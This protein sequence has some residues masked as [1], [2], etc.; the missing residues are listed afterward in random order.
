MKKVLVLFMF[1]ALIAGAAYAQETTGTARAVV[2]DPDGA[3]LPGVTVAISDPDIGLQRTGISDARGIVGFRALPPGTYQLTATLD[4][5]QTYKSS[6]QVNLGSET[7]FDFQMKLGA[8][9]DVIEVTGEAPLVDV[10]S[11]VAGLTVSTDDLN[12]KMPVQR[13]ASYVALLAPATV[14]G[15]TAFNGYTPGQNNISMSGA[16]V[17]ENSYQVNGLNITNFRNGIGSTMVPM[18]FVEEM[19]VKTGGYEAEFGRSTGGVINMVTKSGSNSLHGNFSLYYEPEDLQEQE[20][21][22]YLAPNSDETRET[23]EANASLGGAILKDKLFYFGFVR[24]TDNDFL[25]LSYGQ[26]TRRETSDPYWGG[27][28]DWNITPSHRL[29][30]TYIS[31]DVAVDVTTYD[32]YIP[33]VTGEMCADPSDPAGGM[34]DCLSLALRSAPYPSNG[35]ITDTTGHGVDNR[36]GDNYIIKYT[37]IF[38]E[39]FL[40]SAQ[41]G[42]NQFDRTNKSSGDNSP[43]AFDLRGGGYIHLGSWVNW[44]RGNAFDERKAYRVDADY[45]MG[46]H[47]FRAGVDTEENNSEDLTSYSGGFRVGY[48]DSNTS[49]T[50]AAVNIRH[51]FNGG[52]FD[53]NSD[54][55]YIQDSWAVT[56]NL[57]V[58]LGVRWEKFENKNSLGQTFIE[59]S[60]QYAPRLG[61]IWDPSGEGRSKIYGSYGQYY[62]PI[63]S[64]TNIRMAGGEI[65][66]SATYE[67]DPAQG[68][69]PD[70]TPVGWTNCGVM[71]LEGCG[72]QGSVGNLQT[73]AVYSDGSVPDPKEVLSFNFDP[74]SQDEYILGYE[75]MVG[76]NWSIGVRGVWREFNK[77]IE[78]FTIDDALIARYGMDV[79]Y[80]AF[81]YRL[82]NPGSSFQGYFDVDGDG[83]L[84]PVSFTADELNYPKPERKYGAL[85]FTFKRRFADHWMLQGSY[86]WSH[87]W[88]NYEG[89]VYSDVGQ[90]DAGLTQMFD[91]PG[92]M[93]NSYGNLPQDRRHNL[94]IFGAYAFDS[95]LQIGGNFYYHSGRPINALGVYPD[96]DNPAYLYDA[97]AYFNQGQPVPRGAAG[98]T[99][100]IMGIDGMVKYDFQV[101]GLDMNVRLDVFNIFDNSNPTEVQEYADQDSGAANPHYLDPTHFQQPRRVRLGFG[102]V[103]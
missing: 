86:T 40:L 101:A 49:P 11:T 77:V 27:K 34:V 79:G 26:G 25:G 67:W 58:N 31:D 7:N 14:T 43:Y 89:E 35:Y 99:P 41:Y 72:N 28:L 50:G 93:Q 8:I 24:Y 22:T 20:P 33:G 9:T 47:S 64:N 78:D 96:A 84:D 62:L 95:G 56:P 65:Y 17:A 51:Y 68:Y 1:A 37:G 42:D 13:E 80:G 5:F 70:G 90:D 74:M 60:D 19:Q 100:S 36:G 61:V 59:T 83:V 71:N 2:T 15:D 85:E 91:F 12:A 66:E 46:N 54:A 76:D 82:G 55:A 97:A 29:E 63:A 3:A 92:L 75:K 10:S 39:N 32:Y 94:K 102:L 73:Y 48:Y 69:N 57:T 38:T 6:F 16:S 52:S 98:T 30:G 103:F 53:V 88:G 18:E 21:D 23:M 81:E 87:L 45:Y 44:S 4:G